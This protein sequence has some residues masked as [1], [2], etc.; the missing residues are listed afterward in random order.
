MKIIQRSEDWQLKK[1]P[2]KEVTQQERSENENLG[3]FPKK[4]KSRSFSQKEVMLKGV[5]LLHHLTR[6]L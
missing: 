1:H 2:Q 5:G 6:L 4:R 3:T